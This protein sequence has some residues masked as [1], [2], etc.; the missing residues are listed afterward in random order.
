MYSSL[1]QQG[2]R[3]QSAAICGQIV[4]A[5]HFEQYI[6]VHKCMNR[7]SMHNL[8]KLLH[9]HT[10]LF[11]IHNQSCPFDRRGLW[12]AIPDTHIF[13]FHCSEGADFCTTYHTTRKLPTI[14]GM[15][16]SIKIRVPVTEPII[17]LR[18][19]NLKTSAIPFGTGF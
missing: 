16:V 3:V 14:L 13:W 12:I 18:H 15:Q 2:R 7:L 17:A 19:S 1:M 5:C 10:G 6:Q 8:N 9:F 11:H 4:S